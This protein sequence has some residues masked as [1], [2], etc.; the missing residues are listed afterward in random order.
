MQF[1]FDASFSKN[2]ETKFLGFGSTHNC[3]LVLR[4]DSSKIL[5]PNLD[6][7]FENETHFPWSMCQNL[8]FCEKIDLS[9]ARFQA[10]FF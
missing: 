3:N 8:S 7:S 6:F 10:L 2:T 1:G 5:K 4:P 9:F